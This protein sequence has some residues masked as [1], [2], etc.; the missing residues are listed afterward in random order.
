M[1]NVN[2]VAGGSSLNQQNIQNI[3]SPIQGNNDAAN[4]ARQI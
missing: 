1:A 3:Q 4:L 2:P